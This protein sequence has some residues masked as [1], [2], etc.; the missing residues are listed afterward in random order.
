MRHMQPSK[1]PGPL[2]NPYEDPHRD[3][4]GGQGALRAQCFSVSFPQKG[5]VLGSYEVALEDPTAG[6]V[7]F[8]Q[9]VDPPFKGVHLALLQVLEVVGNVDFL[10]HSL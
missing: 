3:S 9:V 2:G 4:Q 6:A 8:L 7:L 1:L 5:Q 10:R